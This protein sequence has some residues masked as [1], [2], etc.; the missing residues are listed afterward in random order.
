M[1][2]M[3][4]MRANAGRLLLMAPALAL[5]AC[6]ARQ[7]TGSADA[8][9]HAAGVHS[10]AA[11]PAVPGGAMRWGDSIASMSAQ[12]ASPRLSPVSAAGASAWVRPAP[13]PAFVA[14]GPL[15]P[16]DPPAPDPIEAASRRAAAPSASAQAAAD[17]ARPE[18]AAPNTPAAPDPALRTGGLALF[19]DYSCSACHALADAGAAGSIGPSLDRNPRLT[20]SFAIDVIANGRG[21]MPAFA[22][23]MSDDEIAALADYIVHLSRK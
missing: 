1:R 9:S 14:S 17:I 13:A 11:D 12:Y 5:G 8:S 23:Q 10:A 6:A 2:G 15:P 22:G 16:A 3:R 4:T 21:A 7:D 18:A 19:N 20:R